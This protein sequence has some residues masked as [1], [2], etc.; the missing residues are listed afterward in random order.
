MSRGRVSPDAYVI[1]CRYRCG[2]DERSYLAHNVTH[3]DEVCRL[4]SLCV[5]GEGYRA[6]CGLE[7][8]VMAAIDAAR[9]TGW[10]CSDDDHGWW[11]VTAQPIFG[12]DIDPFR[13]ARTS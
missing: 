11:T 10:S 13:M 6:H 4:V 8:S 7:E 9:R 5:K 1:V 2:D 3:A 12:R